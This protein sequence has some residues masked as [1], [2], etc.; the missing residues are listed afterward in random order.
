[1]CDLIEVFESLCE[2]ESDV[3]G[4]VNRI[5]DRRWIFG[6][7]DNFPIQIEYTEGD[8]GFLIYG[9]ALWENGEPVLAPLMVTLFVE[10]LFG[11]SIGGYGISPGPVTITIYQHV[12][13]KNHFD[14]DRLI[15]E[16]SCHRLL[17]ECFIQGV[18]FS[19]DENNMALTD[20][21]GDQ[22]IIPFRH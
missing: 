4:S 6:D 1:M 14:A 12:K 20:I 3:L 5:D 19:D 17:T 21:H 2:I 15:A 10:K 18:A 8:D 11:H 16:V 22:P 13:W 9:T 7:K